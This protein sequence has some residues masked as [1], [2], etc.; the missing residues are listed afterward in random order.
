M[1]GTEAATDGRGTANGGFRLDDTV[2]I[3]SGAGTHGGDGV[4]NGAATAVLFAGRGATVVLVDEERER[5]EATRERIREEDGKAVAVQADV[6]DPDECRAVVERTVEE[7]GGVDVLHNN[8][9]GGPRANV[10]EADDGTWRRSIA[11]NL[12][13]AIYMSRHAVPEMAETGGGAIVNTSSI[14]AR[15]PGYDYL[16]YTVT[17]AGVVG[18]TRGLAIDHARDGI[19]VN[20]IM[21]GPV[22]TPKVASTRDEEDRRL[23][24]ESVPVPREGEP[25]DVG[26]AAVFLASD[27]AGWITG[28]TL[29][30][31]GGALLT[32]GGDRPGMF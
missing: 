19:R 2:A 21:P 6:T 13:S 22:W 24:R 29:P 12:M 20:C 28:V 10:V 16:P 4:G 1:S 26:W 31:D 27:E 7:F 17:K 23:R 3:V 30:V 32:R 8:V 9:G 15:R 5:A 14:Q 11:L 25:W 18:L